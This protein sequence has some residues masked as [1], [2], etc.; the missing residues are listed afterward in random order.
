MERR[1]RRPHLS[2]SPARLPI[3]TSPVHRLDSLCVELRQLGVRSGQPIVVHSALRGLGPIDGGADTVI[4]AL[5]EC[6]G[7]SGTSLFPNLNIPHEFSAANPPRF[8]LQKEPI[9]E[10]LGVLSQVF[11]ASYAREFSRHPTHAMMGAGPHC[12]PLFVGHES[13]GMPCGP[14]TPWWRLATMGGSILLLG[15]TQQNNTSIHGPEEVHAKY[16]LSRD[17]IEGVVIDGGVE[18][19]VRSRLHRWGN[20][21]D[22]GRINPWLER[23]G[24]LRRGRVGNAECLL[25]DAG[26][27][28]AQVCARLIDDP[29]FLLAQVRSPR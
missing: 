14:G 19:R 25:I 16:Q 29:Q 8:D 4:R 15:V 20:A 21:S 3:T 27:F 6:I 23:A 18:Y 22:F 2:F 7:D 26:I 12:G 11:K 17:E 10:R 5:R 28:Q 9:R 13:A 24:G 1:A